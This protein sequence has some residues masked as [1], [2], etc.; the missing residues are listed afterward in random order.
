MGRPVARRPA[1]TSAVAAEVIRLPPLRPERDTTSPTMPVWPRSNTVD[2]ARAPQPRGGLALARRRN[3]SGDVALAR[4]R[5][6]Q[7]ERWTLE[8]KSAHLSPPATPRSARTPRTP[9]AGP[10]APL[11]AER[12]LP[13]PPGGGSRAVA[14]ANRQAASP[15]AP[16]RAAPRPRPRS[17]ALSPIKLQ[18]RASSGTASPTTS[19]ASSVA[20]A[21]SARLALAVEAPPLPPPS[22]AERG[23]KPAPRSRRTARASEAA[24]EVHFDSV[25]PSTPAFPAL[26]AALSPAVPQASER[27]QTHELAAL[28][29][30]SIHSALAPAAMDEQWMAVR[31]LVV[32]TA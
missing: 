7:R 14:G 2:R 32:A 21:V 30:G 26:P 6:L 18:S 4:A 23:G 3:M 27:M 31:N 11:P 5:T 16:S 17:K 20:P 19:V 9:P 29:W 15:T 8:A 12:P 25:V 28:F 1:A 24:G 22:L 10:L 13:S